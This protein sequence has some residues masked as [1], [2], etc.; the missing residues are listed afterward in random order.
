M[1]CRT[2]AT[3]IG[4][5][6]GSDGELVDLQRAAV[7]LPGRDARQRAVG[8]SVRQP[9]PARAAAVSR[10]ACGRCWRW[11]GLLL[12]PPPRV[13]FVY[14][15]AL[16]LAFDMSLGCR[17][18]PIAC[19]TSTCR[20][21]GLRALARLGIFVVF[22]LAALAVYGYVAMAAR[23][24][25]AARPVA[26]DRSGPRLSPEYRVR[27]LE[28]VPYPTRR[29][30]STPGWRSSRAGSSR[31]CR[32][33]RRGCP[34][35]TRRYS[36]LSTFHWH[37][38][39]NGYSGFYPAT[40]LSGSPNCGFSGRTVAA[41][42]AAGWCALPRS[43][44]RRISAGTP[45]PVLCLLRDG[46]GLAELTRQSDGAGEAVCDALP[47]AE[48]RRSS[49][50]S[51]YPTSNGDSRRFSSARATEEPRWHRGCDRGSPGASHDSSGLGNGVRDD[52]LGN[53][54]LRV[55]AANGEHPDAAPRTLIFR[56]TPVVS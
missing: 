19:C 15:L 46:F 35:T 10:R 27:P 38:I 1:R 4:W 50:N 2:C 24:P 14:L 55:D 21:P 11:S 13:A 52:W 9:R 43:P 30:R 36:Y 40:Y 31:S 5:A 3:K 6:D 12:R 20:F 56:N 18:T 53:R 51:N 42:P 26:G 29:R 22:F 28:L 8:P 39:V 32:C 45:R 7:Q 37:P 25:R 16:A 34:A 23:L 47:L 54:F 48:R 17:A 41:P 44:Y 33:A 49:P